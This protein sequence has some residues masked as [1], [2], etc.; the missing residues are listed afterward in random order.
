MIKHP[1]DMN[2]MFNIFTLLL[3]VKG[4]GVLSTI[5]MF[6]GIL[7]QPDIALGMGNLWLPGTN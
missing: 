4:G 6:Q 1:S 3:K 2:Y 5:D 7:W